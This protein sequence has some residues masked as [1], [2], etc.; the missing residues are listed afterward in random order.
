VTTASRPDTPDEAVA[1]L[2][3]L[4]DGEEHLAEVV[5]LGEAAVAPLEALLRGPADAVF[6]H[7]A[8]AA[9]ALAA[10]GGRPA[11]AALTRALEDSAT[12]TLT[13]AREAAELALL[14]RIARRLAGVA[15][16]AAREPLLAVLARRC[17]PG[18][19]AA[20]GRLRERRALPRLVACLEDGYA[21]G[22]C[23]EALRAFGDAAAPALIAR[24]TELRIDEGALG[25]AARA[26]ALELL[27]ECAPERARPLARAALTDPQ[28]AVRLAGAS[29]LAHA[30]EADATA[31]EVLMTLLAEP[32][33]QIVGAA[34][35]ALACCGERARALARRTLAALPGRSSPAID[36]A[37]LRQVRALPQVLGGIGVSALPELER[38]LDA[39]DPPTRRAA[40]RALD[41]LQGNRSSVRRLL[42]RAARDPDEGVRA[43][44]LHAADRDTDL[45]GLLLGLGDPRH[46]LA[47]QAVAALMRQPW[48]TL[49]S[50]HVR[51][52]LA[53]RARLR[54]VLLTLR[55]LARGR[56]PPG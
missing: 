20:L 26:A 17:D 49:L 51:P 41:A 13:G 15:G 44:A 32:D 8:R 24:L 30:G 22:A 33:P 10:I 4:A 55:R 39:A 52:G 53:L 46:A 47:Q 31:C 29:W 38:L 2:A 18:C 54:L 25:A 19:C 27:G 11:A 14:S 45:P 6:E 37:R 43:I 40:L 36:P 42:H 5:A 48:A 12:R 50:A 34:T 21:Q 23:R 16:R 35:E 1:R 56:M 9:D 28:L 7:R 3:A